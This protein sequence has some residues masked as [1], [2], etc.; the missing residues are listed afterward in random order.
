M[1]YHVL[2]RGNRQADVFLQPADFDAFLETIAEAI[3]R[4]PLDLFGYCLMPNHVHLVVR[5]QKNGDLG[6]WMR[7]L[8]MS[9]AQRHHRCYKTIGHVWQGRYK[10]FPVQDDGHLSTLLRYVERNPVR[11][12]LV[13][14][15]QFWKW[16]SLA[17]RLSDDPLLWRDPPAPSK[18]DWLSRVNLPHD[19]AELERL[20]ESAGRERPYGSDDWTLETA[21][22]L[23]LE[24]TLRRRGRP[25]KG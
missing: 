3:A 23:G 7:W 10:A 19:R 14:K 6:H 16:S 24:S 21:R 15:P 13:A 12:E 9:H 1:I 25:R 17:G 11:S 20:R 2:N 22:Q 18:T 5:P 4:R 8:L